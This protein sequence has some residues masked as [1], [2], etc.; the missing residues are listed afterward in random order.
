MNQPQVQQYDIVIIG[1]GIIGSSVAYHVL[2]RDPAARVCVVE[3]DPSYEF[4]SAL[5]SSG[6][7]RVQFTCPE[8]I[9]MS[10][11]SLDVIKNFENTMA[12]NG[13][14]A[15]VDWVQGG[16]LFLVPPER[17]AMLERNVARQQAMAA[18]ST[19]LPPPN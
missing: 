18:R 14:P 7:C 11:Y 4:A 15:P 16:Y 8:N 5:R 2:A 9:A 10:L 6:G 13:R 3:P 19:C 1:G 12:A 17:V